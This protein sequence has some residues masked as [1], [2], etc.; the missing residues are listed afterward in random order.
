MWQGNEATRAAPQ[1]RMDGG[2]GGI[3]RRMARQRKNV[4]GRRGQ[5]WPNGLSRRRA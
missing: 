4:K 1:P 3:A 2:T 5:R